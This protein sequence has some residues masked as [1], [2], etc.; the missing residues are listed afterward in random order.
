MY[1]FSI[2]LGAL[3]AVSRSI[4]LTTS[5]NFR[6]RSPAEGGK[7]PAGRVYRWEAASPNLRFERLTVPG[8]QEGESRCAAN[9]FTRR[10]C[11]RRH[12]NAFVSLE[13]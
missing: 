3:L 2:L 1:C 7:L 13:T 6:R 4:T 5:M 11:V 12:L 8:I 10:L 9:G